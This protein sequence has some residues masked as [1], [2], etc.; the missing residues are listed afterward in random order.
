MSNNQFPGLCATLI[1]KKHVFNRQL[2]S[3]EG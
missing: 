1:S 2:G 3:I